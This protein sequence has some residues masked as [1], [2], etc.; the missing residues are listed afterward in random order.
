MDD[1][2][3]ESRT[4]LA[5][6][7]EAEFEQLPETGGKARRGLKE[8]REAERVDEFTLC[9]HA[10]GMFWWRWSEDLGESVDD[11]RLI[12]HV[13]AYVDHY[14][15]LFSHDN[16]GVVR[17][18]ATLS[19]EE[20]LAKVQYAVDVFDPDVGL[21][22]QAQTS[23]RDSENGTMATVPMRITR[24]VLQESPYL[25]KDEIVARVDERHERDL[26]ER[27]RKRFIT[28]WKEA[29]KAKLAQNYTENEHLW[30]WHT[31]PDP[32]G[33]DE[34]VSASD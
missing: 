14:A 28:E 20:Q 31:E 13:H 5:L 1:G 2:N 15:N 4:R 24:K 22:W 19:S 8:L 32:D 7:V 11:E 25:S 30:Y 10:T 23:K 27:Y 16:D 18:W 34:I 21:Y 3:A 33:A 29:G 17:E 6:D 9:L 12:K 26:T